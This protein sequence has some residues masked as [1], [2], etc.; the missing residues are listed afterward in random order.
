MLKRVIGFKFGY[1]KIFTICFGRIV[2][3]PVRINKKKRERKKKKNNVNGFPLIDVQHTQVR[4]TGSEMGSRGDGNR[5]NLQSLF[6][7]AL[8][9]SITSILYQEF[10]DLLGSATERN[11]SSGDVAGSKKRMA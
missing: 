10:Y 9:V 6:F 4:L 7:S 11:E 8:F 3:S 2:R 1:F 5:C